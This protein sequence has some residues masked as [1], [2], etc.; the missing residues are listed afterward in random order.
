MKTWEQRERDHKMAKLSA[1]E[2]GR[3]PVFYFYAPKKSEGIGT[4]TVGKLID[5]K[6]IPAVPGDERRK[7]DQGMVIIE[8][9][10]KRGDGWDDVRVNFTDLSVAKILAPL[11]IGSPSRPSVKGQ[12]VGIVVS[13]V[14]GEKEYH[15]HEIFV[16][17]APMA[18][19]LAEMNADPCVDLLRKHFGAPDFTFSFCTWFNGIEARYAEWWEKT[20]GD[21][22]VHLETGDNI[23]F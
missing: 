20:A 15:R 1:Q 19:R 6:V 21:R 11:T 17:G 4:F 7:Y 10:I 5:A 23:P 16:D 3:I 9:R 8:T 13:G 22:G 2:M 14:S 12:I 18:E